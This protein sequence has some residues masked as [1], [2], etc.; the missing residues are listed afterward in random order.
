MAEI[1]ADQAGC[2]LDGHMGWHN[3][4]RVI[5]LAFDYGWTPEDKPDIERIVEI[6]K[7]N[8]SVEC[9]DEEMDN[10][11][12]AIHDISQE[13]TDYLDSLAPRGY[14]FQWDMGELCLVHEDEMEF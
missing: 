2:W 3:T 5:D 6:F 10:A 1:T 4:Y 9:S 8:P 13:A 11:H 12:D 14:Y 7:G